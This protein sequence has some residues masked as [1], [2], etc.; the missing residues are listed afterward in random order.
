MQTTKVPDRTTLRSPQG[1]SPETQ[2]PNIKSTP[3][4]AST[5]SWRLLLKLAIL[6]YIKQD[7]PRVVLR[8]GAGLRVHRAA[9]L[10]PVA[11]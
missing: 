3:V 4:N 8:L 2:S 5:S 11:S 6:Y 10:G 9:V 1:G 7:A